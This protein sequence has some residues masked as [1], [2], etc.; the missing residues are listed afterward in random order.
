MAVPTVVDFW[1]D[2]GCPYSWIGSRWLLEVEQRR[3]L[4]I[5]WHTMSLY[6]LNESRTEDASYV[7]Y[8]RHVMGVARVATA[9]MQLGGD[10]LRD[11]YTAYGA[12]I[13]DR[14][15]YPGPTE[16]REAVEKALA[17]AGLPGELIQAF[18]R[19]DDDAEL[20]RSHLEGIAV[21]GDEAG[22]PLTRVDGVAFFGPVLNSIP[23]GEDALRVFDGAVLLAGFHDFFEIKRT[24]TSEP[25]YS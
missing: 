12:Q 22:T 7:E 16:C 25:V 18:D 5:R 1:F 20:R 6:L 21:V 15:R 23:R 3:P 9:A 2:P 4:D 8:L 19:L 10:A 24:R 11:L 17:R 14:W 13:F